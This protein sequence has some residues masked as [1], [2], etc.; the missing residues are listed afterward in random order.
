MKNIPNEALLSELNT[1]V[2]IPEENKHTLSKPTLTVTIINLNA[3]LPFNNH[4]Q[5][6]KYK[7]L[8][9]HVASSYKYVL[10]YL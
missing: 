2:N 7:R 6:E 9:C 8:C 4:V 3:T 10:I 5:K 1:V